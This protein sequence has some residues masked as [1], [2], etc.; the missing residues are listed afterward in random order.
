MFRGGTKG[1]GDYIKVGW[2]VSTKDD[3]SGSAQ[4]C[5]ASGSV[6]ETAQA[7][8]RSPGASGL[9]ARGCAA[10][11]RRPSSTKNCSGQSAV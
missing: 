11:A 10:T 3:P 8:P 7:A 6:K 1:L 9:Q 2:F 4:G 5:E